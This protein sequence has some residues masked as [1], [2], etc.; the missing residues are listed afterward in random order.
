MT[1]GAGCPAARGT[2]PGRDPGVGEGRRVRG[3]GGARVSAPRFVLRDAGVGDYAAVL[4]LNNAAVPAVNFLDRVGLERIV[5]LGCWFRVAEDAEG[6]AGV[7]L[8]IPSGGA[9]WSA[10]Y[11]WFGER[12]DSFLYLDRVVVAERVRGQGVG[13]LLYGEMHAFAGTRWPRV[14]LEV[15]RRPPNPGSDRFHRRLGYEAVGEREYDSG[16]VTMYVR[17]VETGRATACR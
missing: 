10:N 17:A 12:Y 8:C 15:N 1:T 5:A 9:Y 7:V 11:A 3:P 6:V 14:V 16:A 2:G 4:A 13:G